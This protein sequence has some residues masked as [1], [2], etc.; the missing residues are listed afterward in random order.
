[1]HYNEVHIDEFDE[2]VIFS[3]LKDRG[4]KVI[5]EKDNLPVEF[6]YVKRRI[7]DIDDFS[8]RE[9]E[10]HQLIDELCDRGY[11]V[12]KDYEYKAETG[13]KLS[14]DE[15]EMIL[16]LIPEVNGDTLRRKML[17]IVRDFYLGRN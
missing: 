16:N 4:V 8:I 5:H 9:A 10:D 14:K 13:V 1:M 12:M 3:H 7:I 6:R 2:N 11:I 17:E 15:C